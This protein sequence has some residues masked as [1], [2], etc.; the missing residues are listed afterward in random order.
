MSLAESAVTR[1][2]NA[3]RGIPVENLDYEIVMW[4]LAL[5]TDESFQSTQSQYI[6]RVNLNQ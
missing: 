4:Q 2:T 6:E 1:R 5:N 3:K